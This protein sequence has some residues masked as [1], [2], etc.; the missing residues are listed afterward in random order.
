MFQALPDIVTSTVVSQDQEHDCTQLAQSMSSSARAEL[1]VEVEIPGQATLPE[2]HARLF[3]RSKPGEPVDV[4]SDDFLRASPGIARVTISDVDTISGERRQ[5]ACTNDELSIGSKRRSSSTPRTRAR[6]RRT[7]SCTPCVATADV[8]HRSGERVAGAARA[9]QHAQDYRV[10]R[11]G[12]QHGEGDL[13][14][15]VHVVSRWCALVLVACAACSAHA[16]GSIGNHASP[17]RHGDH[18]VSR[19]RGD[20][21]AP[22]GRRARSGQRRDVR[23]ARRGREDR[24]R[25]D[26]RSRRPHGRRLGP[27]QRPARRTARRRASIPTSAVTMTRRS[28]TRSRPRSR[29]RSPRSSA[30]A[31]PSAS[32]SMSP[33]CT[34]G[35][36]RSHGTRRRDA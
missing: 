36:R 25:R 22:R 30:P 10:P 31:S 32:S 12:D 2:G 8:A 7:S 24:R 15:G 16:H 33:G 17:A 6:A 13:H 4:V 34:R 26:P 9:R 35:T 29:R 18:A 14:R 20:R 1:G 3:R 5:I 11:R 27:R 23:D 21:A 28:S 19:R